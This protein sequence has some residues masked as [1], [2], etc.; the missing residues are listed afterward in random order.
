MGEIKAHSEVL[1]LV[2]AFTR[3]D[4][5]FEWL[6]T[7]IEETWGAIALESSEFSYRL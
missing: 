4:E 5:G 6:R 7:K 2:A 1:L 3:Y